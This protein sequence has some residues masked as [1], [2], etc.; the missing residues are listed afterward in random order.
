MDTLLQ[1]FLPDRIRRTKV[2]LK[3]IQNLS[4]AKIDWL[5][6]CMGITGSRLYQ[7][8]DPNKPG[9]RFYLDNLEIFITETGDF[10]VLDDIEARL[11]RVAFAE[12]Q[13]LASVNEIN[14]QVSRV[15]ADCAGV[16]QAMVALSGPDEPEIPWEKYKQIKANIRQAQKQLAILENAARQQAVRHPS[17]PRRLLQLAAVKLRGTGT[18]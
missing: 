11:G 8:L 12:P 13:A 17:W 18:K 1:D 2:R 10:G 7:Q 16:C 9:D 4:P 6:H 3:E 14:L 15:F 5:A